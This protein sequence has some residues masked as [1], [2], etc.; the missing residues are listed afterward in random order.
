MGG[1]STA[2]GEEDRSFLENQGF[3]IQ[4]NAA[5]SHAAEPGHRDL[6][7]GARPLIRWFGSP[8]GP[9]GRTDDGVR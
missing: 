3:E 8:P 5:R 2:G 6:A 7:S 1:A 4:T 9:I